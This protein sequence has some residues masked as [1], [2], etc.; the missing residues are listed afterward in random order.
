MN[1]LDQELDGDDF[2][3]LGGEDFRQHQR[4]GREVVLFHVVLLCV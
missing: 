3:V 1:R 4:V 2:A